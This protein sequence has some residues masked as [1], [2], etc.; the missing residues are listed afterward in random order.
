MSVCCSPRLFF[1][2]ASVEDDLPL[3]VYI[4]E[5]CWCSPAASVDGTRNSADLTP[6]GHDVTQTNS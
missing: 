2:P 3:S 1:K 4:D 6:G 5:R